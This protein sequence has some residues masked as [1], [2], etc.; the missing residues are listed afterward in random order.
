MVLAL[1]LRFLSIDF[2]W[3]LTK[4]YEVVESPAFDAAM[5]KWFTTFGDRY[6]IMNGD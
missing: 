2:L 5:L 3:A 1:S 4:L 6:R